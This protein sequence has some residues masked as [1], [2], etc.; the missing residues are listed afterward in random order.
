[1]PS[2][3]YYILSNC[4]LML[5]PQRLCC[6]GNC[7]TSFSHPPVLSNLLWWSFR[8]GLVGP[9]QYCLPACGIKGAR[10]RLSL[11][12]T[13]GSTMAGL[14]DLPV[15]VLEQIILD[16]DRKT[17]LSIRRCSQLILAIVKG[18][19]D[20]ESLALSSKLRSSRGR[21][22]FCTFARISRRQFGRDATA[23]IARRQL[24][25]N[26]KVNSQG[27][28]QSHFIEPMILE[29]EAMALAGYK[30]EHLIKLLERAD[31]L[32]FK[33]CEDR[34]QALQKRF[35][36]NVQQYKLDRFTQ[37]YL[38]LFS[39]QTT[40]YMDLFDTCIREFWRQSISFLDN[41]EVETLSN[42]T[43]QRI[44]SM[45]KVQMDQNLD[46]LV[47]LSNC[48][49]CRRSYSYSRAGPGSS[50]VQRHC[51]C[52]TFSTSVTRGWPCHY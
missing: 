29:A 49:S 2:E 32:K 41:H 21:S 26:Q 14:Q 35:R 42:A 50:F 44:M 23:R 25:T 51:T 48:S 40:Q 36:A 3:A 30:N 33:R 28:W 47:E 38:N 6:A 20:P 1:M 31:S 15:E 17:L 27:R 7:T 37:I 22:A 11:L 24:R 39:I 46:Y 52:C 4:A 45:K 13:T 19:Y 9:W 43:S 16:L 8:H 12:L 18:L 34:H 10:P 5:H